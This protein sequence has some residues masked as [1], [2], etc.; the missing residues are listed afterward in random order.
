MVQS[1]ECWVR[2]SVSRKEGSEEDT[3]SMMC[4]H[5]GRQPRSALGEVDSKQRMEGSGV[6]SETDVSSAV[7]RKL[8]RIELLRMQVC[9]SSW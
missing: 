7:N 5:L 3:P 2:A 9:S 1:L 4:D 8:D 6:L